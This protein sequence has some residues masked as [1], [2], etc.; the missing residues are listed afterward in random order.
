MQERLDKCPCSGIARGNRGWGAGVSPR[1]ADGTAESDCERCHE[2]PA[3][4]RFDPEASASPEP[5]PSVRPAFSSRPS[6][7][8][9]YTRWSRPSESRRL[10]QWWNSVGC[11]ASAMSLSSAIIE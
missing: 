11:A 6:M 1:D 4:L 2:R 10:S 3:R 5:T 7:F 8:C 9:V